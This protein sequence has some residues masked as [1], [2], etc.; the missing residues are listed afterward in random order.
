LPRGAEF[1]EAYPLDPRVIKHIPERLIGRM[2]PLAMAADL[3]KDTEH[4][5]PTPKR[6]PAESARKLPRQKRPGA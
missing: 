6:P 5:D 4:A 2:I 1:A 3:L